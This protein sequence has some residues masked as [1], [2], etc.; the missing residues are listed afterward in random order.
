MFNLPRTLTRV[1]EHFLD[2]DIEISALKADI[3]KEYNKYLNG[4]RRKLAF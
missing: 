3:Y 2:K 1:K 4:R